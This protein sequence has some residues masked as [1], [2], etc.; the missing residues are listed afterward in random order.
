MA[1]LQ[2]SLSSRDVPSR[3]PVMT[4]SSE[5]TGA[6][7]PGVDP[8]PSHRR[9]KHRSAVFR[10]FS[11]DENPLS[12][13]TFSTA[14]GSYFPRIPSNAPPPVICTS[15]P[16]GEPVTY[17]A[18]ENELG[19]EVANR[20]LE[21]Q[22]RHPPQFSE[23][24][25]Q[26]F[27]E[28]AAVLP[29]PS[30]VHSRYDAAVH[31]HFSHTGIVHLPPRGTSQG[32]SSSSSG[33]MGSASRGRTSRSSENGT[34]S[35]NT[36]ALPEEISIVQMPS[37]QDHPHPVSVIDSNET[38]SGSSLSGSSGSDAPRITFKHQHIEDENGHH[39]IVGREGKISRCEDEVCIC[40]FV[41]N[42]TSWSRSPFAPPV[43]C[44]ALVF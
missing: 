7:S 16:T 40:Y 29:M 30:D 4:P 35:L 1:P 6:G 43:P 21:Y 44:K 42:V 18:A 34:G 32:S 11:P 37:T 26:A 2:R 31:S 15:G 25:S 24:A 39:L 14:T 10:D 8:R 9:R 28:A 41:D 22:A 38:G 3:S 23:V 13:R 33:S 19:D 17:S 36:Q 5:S 20:L 27:A 12:P